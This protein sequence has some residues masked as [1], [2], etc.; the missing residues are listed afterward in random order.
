MVSECK[1]CEVLARNVALEEEVKE[2]KVLLAQTRQQMQE[3]RQEASVRS[4]ASGQR[5]GGDSW[6][7]VDRGGAGLFRRSSGSQWT[8]VGNSR[9]QSKSR[10]CWAW[11]LAACKG[12]QPWRGVDRV[13]WVM[14]SLL[15][16]S[17]WKW[18]ASR[19]FFLPPYTPLA[20]PGVQ[21]SSLEDGRSRHYG[22]AS[23]DVADGQRDA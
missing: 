2:V 4:R 21:C 5:Q 10:A 13:A 11:L 16:P 18:L 1:L 17:R 7:V 6:R 19:Y 15:P 8:Q 14:A 20:K 9:G 23:R 3:V 22:R 12:V